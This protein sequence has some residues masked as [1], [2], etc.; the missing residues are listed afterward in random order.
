MKKNK[1]KSIH[2]VTLREVGEV[3]LKIALMYPIGIGL[4]A[5]MNWIDSI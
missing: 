1:E 5:I 3:I 2:R 4:V